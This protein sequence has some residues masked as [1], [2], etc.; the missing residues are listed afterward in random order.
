MKAQDMEI[1]ELSTPH[2]VE[3]LELDPDSAGAGQWR[4][5]YGTR[6]RFRFLGEGVRGSTLGDDSAAEGAVPGQGLF[7][8]H[9]GGLNTL[10]LTLP[11]G[12]VRDWG[13]KEAVAIPTG[14]L[15]DSNHGGGA[16]YGDPL[17][18][19]PR[20]VVDEVREGLLTA[21]RAR[22]VY[23]VA[24]RDDASG[25]DEAETERLRAVAVGGAR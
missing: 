10:R 1:F 11:D 23:G 16:G 5:G 4:G 15:C 24:V 12:T 2:H 18:R 13:S 8:G 20:L 3:Y 17:A 7:G 19:D 6:S 21:A 9:D 14:T 22:E 25:Y